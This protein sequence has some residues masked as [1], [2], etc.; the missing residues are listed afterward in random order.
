MIKTY[1]IFY[2]NPH[3]FYGNSYVH[4]LTSLNN[5]LLNTHLVSYKD[6]WLVPNQFRSHEE[7]LEWFEEFS[8]R[9]KKDI[10]KYN[11]EHRNGPQ[12]LNPLPKDIYIIESYHLITL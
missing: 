6:E 7:A 9:V 1:E 3:P 12:K 10:T 8:E 5:I 11:E 2:K 4:G